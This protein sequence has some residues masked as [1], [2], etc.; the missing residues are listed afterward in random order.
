MG[1]VLLAVLRNSQSSRDPALPEKAG[2]EVGN[3]APEFGLEDQTGRKRSLDDLL[4]ESKYVALVF[5][6]SAHW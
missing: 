4:R 2:L 5:F 1:L 3:R 6:R